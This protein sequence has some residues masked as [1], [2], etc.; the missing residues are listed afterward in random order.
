M[1][2]EAAAHNMGIYYIFLGIVFVI[3]FLFWLAFESGAVYKAMDILEKDKLDK[4]TK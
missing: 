4:K 2:L 1:F 3:I